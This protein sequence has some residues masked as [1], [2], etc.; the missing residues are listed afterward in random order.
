MRDITL[1]ETID[2]KFTTTEPD[3]GAPA[4]LSGTPVISAYVGNSVTQI[5]AG[6]TLSVDFDAVTGLNNVRV[7]ATSGNGYTD[8]SDV[9]LI[10]TTGTVDAVSAVGY[11]VAEFTIGRAAAYTR[12]GAPAGASVS[13]DIAAVKVDTAAILVDTAEIGAAG[14]GLTALATQTSVNTIDDLLDTEVAALT[15]ELAKVPK[16]DGTATWNATA[17]AALQSEAND[18]LVAHRLDELLNA[19]SDIDGAA[20]PTVGS[21]FHELMT[22]TAGS[23]TFDQTTDS[24]EA[25]R[26]NMGTAQTGDSFARL[27]APAG[28]SVSA[29]VAA[30]KVDTAA[31]LVDTGTTLDARIPAALVGGRMDASVGAMAAGTITAAAIA[32]G[33]VDADALAAD[34]V[35][36][37]A[38][39]V[40]DEAISGHVGAGSTGSALNDA[41]VRGDRV[42]VRGTVGAA[43]S[44][45]SIVTSAFSPAG[46]AADQFKGRIVVFDNDTT[47]TSLQGQATS[48]SAS[49]GASLP[50]L[51]VVALTTAPASGDTFSVL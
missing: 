44:T 25:V 27:G 23:F 13:A 24:L 39:G 51:T 48:I 26:D 10:I 9:A 20:P 32:T 14:A 22:K 8:N 5:T 47:T 28:A 46:V 21:V 18:A 45:T 29:D 43:S 37:I 41:D 19:D 4:T 16:S 42:V 30:V 34:A 7:V 17:L 31:I 3:T 2:F 49:T 15:T 6:I 1:G 40:W 33:A 50:V 12:V 11:K 38:D 35:A 36:E